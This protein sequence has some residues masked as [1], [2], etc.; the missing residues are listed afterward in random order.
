MKI[1]VVISTYNGEEY[2]EEQLLSLLHQQ[3]PAD[4]VLIFDDCSTDGTCQ[5][6]EDFL[7]QHSPEG[8]TLTG[9][10]SNKGWRKNFADGMLAAT[11]DL[12]FPCDQDD[13]WKDNKLFAM[14]KIMR[15]HPEISLLT[16]NYEAFYED[17]HTEVCPEPEDRR[18]VR[19]KPVP[20]FF[21][22]LCPGCTY[23][24]RR[25]FLDK[26]MVYWQEDFPHDALL[27]RL[28]MFS[29]SLYSYNEALI[30]WRRHGSSAYTRESLQQKTLSAKREWI[31]YGIRFV[32]AMQRYL[33]NEGKYS[34][35]KARILQGAFQWLRCRADFFDKKS[36]FSGL[37]L[38]KYRK[39]YSRPRQYPGDWYLVFLKRH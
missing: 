36:I 1:S 22:T 2:I 18:L 23:C 27:W 33:E 15:D 8:W 10:E 13:I 31:D 37:A 35:D 34:A 29:D 26:A 16:S 25:S 19:R 39:Y 7:A 32:E 11:G 6:I 4:E 9:N 14:E 5:V 38:L 24:V 30:R 17:G 20:D 3:R 21:T 28:A 12:I